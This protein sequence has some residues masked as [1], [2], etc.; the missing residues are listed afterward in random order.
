[1][2][3]ETFKPNYEPHA[4]PAGPRTW[5]AL[6]SGNGEYVIVDDTDYDPETICTIH[7]AGPHAKYTAADNAKMIADLPI[8]SNELARLRSLNAK[9]LA[10]LEEF[11]K[12]NTSGEYEFDT[13]EPRLYKAIVN[14]IAEAKRTVSKEQKT[15]TTVKFE[16][17]DKDGLHGPEHEITLENPDP[18][19]DALRHA[20]RRV[21][22]A[23]AAAQKQAQWERCNIHFNGQTIAVLFD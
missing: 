14:A 16:L 6:P 19:P 3:P 12:I 10:V 2:D 20:L 1:M 5:K 21:A 13:N 17:Q 22:S 7:A 8:I 18:H 15:M 11:V 23:W 9:L 4:M